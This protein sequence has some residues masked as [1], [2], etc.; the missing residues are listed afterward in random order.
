MEWERSGSRDP[1]LDSLVD[2]HGCQREGG[3]VSVEG[4]GLPVLYTSRPRFSRLNRGW[5][6]GRGDEGLPVTIG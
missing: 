1:C 2:S 5:R 4:L 6:G 3:C